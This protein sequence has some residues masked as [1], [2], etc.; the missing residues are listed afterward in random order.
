M[1]SHLRAGL[2]V[3]LV[4][5]V[6]NIVFALLSTMCCCPLFVYPFVTGAIAGVVAGWLTI[7]WASGK[8]TRPALGGAIAGTLAAI[9]GMIGLALPVAGLVL[10]DQISGFEDT[11][12][13]DIPYPTIRLEELGSYL[14]L[15]AI[16]GGLLVGVAVLLALTAG[17]GA[18][19]A[20]YRTA[21][22]AYL[23][24]EFSSAG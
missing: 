11:I 18:I 21:T 14:I 4:H 12:A 5:M 17:L 13:I 15:F 8:P 24:S 9:G 6:V 20:E 22:K 10:V 7:E 16:V 2:V 1:E 3:G 19:A 23:E